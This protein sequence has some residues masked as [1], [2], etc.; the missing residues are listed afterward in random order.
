MREYLG[1]PEDAKCFAL[2]Y[3]EGRR[4]QERAVQAIRRRARGRIVDIGCAE[5]ALTAAMGAIAGVDKDADNTRWAKAAFPGIDFYTC[6]IQRCPLP[7]KYDTIV[8]CRS[9]HEFSAPRTVLRNLRRSLAQ[10]G[11]LLVVEQ[12][13]YAGRMGTHLLAAGYTVLEALSLGI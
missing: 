5:G 13:G 6:D 3:E 1:G 7:A 9:L 10:G 11:N 8:L 2:R 4:A 12:A